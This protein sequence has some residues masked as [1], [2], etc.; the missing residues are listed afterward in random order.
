MY[1]TERDR[2]ERQAAEIVR[3]AKRLF[4][5]FDSRLVHALNEQRLANART[6]DDA[7][8]LQKVLM[9]VVAFR[10]LVVD[11]CDHEANRIVEEWKSNFEV[12]HAPPAPTR[13]RS[14]EGVCP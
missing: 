6:R 5:E 9:E 13:P 10:E 12:W 2:L 11:A 1:E 8:Q 4:P 7:I 14:S 3:A